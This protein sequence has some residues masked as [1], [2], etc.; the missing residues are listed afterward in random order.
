MKEGAAFR[1]WYSRAGFHLVSRWENG[2]VWGSDFR[3][4]THLAADGGSDIPDID[5][6]S[7]HGR[8]QN[9]PP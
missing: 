6:F 7:G 5:F 2:D 9:P 4:G 1:H 3:D 8:R